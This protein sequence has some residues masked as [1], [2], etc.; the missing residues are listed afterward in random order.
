[1]KPVSLQCQTLAP[2]TFIF[3]NLVEM[4]GCILAAFIRNT[5]SQHV[6]LGHPIL[7]GGTLK[8]FS[9]LLDGAA[10]VGDR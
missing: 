9:Q 1:M 10:K 4:I 5:Y 3:R 2:I 7:N 8:F 6:I